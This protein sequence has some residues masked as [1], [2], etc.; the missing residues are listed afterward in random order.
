MSATTVKIKSLVTASNTTGD[1]IR[2]GLF[3]LLTVITAQ[4]SI[5]VPPV[6]FTLQTVAVVLAGA[7]LGA[8]KG[9]ISQ[10]LYLMLGVIGLPVFA[11]SADA[12]LGLARLMGPTGGYLLAFP[13][14][15]YI[16][17]LM[18]EK[19]KSN[20]SLLAAITAGNLV[21]LLSGVMF[22]SAFYMNDF[23]QAVLFGAGIFSVWS[24]VKI[25]LTYGIYKAVKK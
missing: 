11:L 18:I 17:G 21:V 7:M 25:A 22:L 3:A 20:F 23:S 13:V 24:V 2:V 5:P 4:I 1:V 12:T 14:A 6:P 10:I 8:K 15:A 16:S 9:A 19:Y